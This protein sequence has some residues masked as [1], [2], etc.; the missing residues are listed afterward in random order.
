MNRTQLRERNP[1]RSC[2]SSSTAQLL[3]WDSLLTSI[4]HPVGSDGLSRQGEG[5]QRGQRELHDEVQ[6]G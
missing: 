6:R 3:H 5:G 2:R 1:P 4:A